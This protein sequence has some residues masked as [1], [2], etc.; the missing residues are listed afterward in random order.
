M[1]DVIIGGRC[2]L[3]QRPVTHP[4]QYHTAVDCWSVASS[5]HLLFADH[6]C[7]LV[8][9]QCVLWNVTTEKFNWRENWCEM[10]F[11]ASCGV[12]MYAT[13]NWGRCPFHRVSC[14]F[15]QVWDKMFDFPFHI[16][17]EH[18]SAI[19]LI[20]CLS[21]TSA[22]LVSLWPNAL[23]WSFHW[24][25]RGASVLRH[26]NSSDLICGIHHY[27]FWIICPSVHSY[28]G[29]LMWVW[30]PTCLYISCVRMGMFISLF[31]IIHLF[32]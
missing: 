16:N 10:K 22:H 6:L 11:P 26:Q 14:C 21:K 31:F 2:L 7:F 3:C 23:Y 13:L 1:F 17:V 8:F 19:I 12:F 32:Q 27:W 18:H 24:T 30:L 25:V 20:R 5:Y 9:H 4:H 28:T 29:V 15:W